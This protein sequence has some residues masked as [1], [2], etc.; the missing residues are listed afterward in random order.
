M[1]LMARVW[2]QGSARS[3]RLFGDPSLLQDDYT[4]THSVTQSVTRCKL[5]ALTINNT[6]YYYERLTISPSVRRSH[7]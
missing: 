1:A 2:R 7:S 3:R 5:L 4:Y 6:H